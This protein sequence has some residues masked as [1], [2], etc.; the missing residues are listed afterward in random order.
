MERE[1]PSVESSPYLGASEDVRKARPASALGRTVE[2][3]YAAFHSSAVGGGGEIP[4]PA[5][6]KS[7]TFSPK[8]PGS[9]SDKKLVLGISA[10]SALINSDQPLLRLVGIAASASYGL[11][12]TVFHRRF[13]PLVASSCRPHTFNIQTPPSQIPGY[14]CTVRERASSPKM[15]SNGRLAARV[16]PSSAHDDKDY[17]EEY[18]KEDA[19]LEAWKMLRYLAA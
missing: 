13:V 16:V 17:P 4:G 14:G 2:Q 6:V 7:R 15:S 8:L 10:P 1:G 11:P 12:L 5:E 19:A 9:C 3:R 18:Q